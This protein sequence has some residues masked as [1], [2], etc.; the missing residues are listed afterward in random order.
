MCQ[1]MAGTDFH[2]VRTPQGEEAFERAQAAA[3]QAAQ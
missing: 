2:G 3:R 1:L